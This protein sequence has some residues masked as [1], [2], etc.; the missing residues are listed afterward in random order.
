V[1]VA[2]FAETLGG[3]GHARASGLKL[4]GMSLELAR[5]RV[6]KA[7]AE[8]MRNHRVTSPPPERDEV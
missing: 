1:D 8:W 2:R 3:G 6:V 4:D 7:M 5:D